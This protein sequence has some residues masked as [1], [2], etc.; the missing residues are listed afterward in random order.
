MN[1][2]EPSL[3]TILARRR[4]QRPTLKRNDS[5]FTATVSQAKS[6]ENVDVSRALEIVSLDPSQKDAIKED[7]KLV[8]ALKSEQIPDTPS[9]E[10]IPTI[11]TPNRYDTW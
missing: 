4:H 3:S 9:A 10:K 1:R 6:D 7:L 2:Q 5:S 8:H 11:S